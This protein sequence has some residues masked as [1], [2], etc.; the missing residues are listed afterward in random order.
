MRFLQASLTLTLLTTVYAHPHEQVAFTDHDTDAN[1]NI[2][3]HT[4]THT[5]AHHHHTPL[6]ISSEPWASKYGPQTDTGH[7]GILSF[8]HL[9]YHHCLQSATT[10]FDIAILGFPFD[11]TTSYRPG[12]RFGP[13][14]IRSGSRRQSARG[15]TLPW[16]ASPYEL[17]AGMVDCGDVSA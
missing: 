2:V 4:H 13:F 17:G 5:H 9:P 6:D 12:A 1:T 15:Y 16:G 7:S 11:T 8:S 3:P 10:S 14:G